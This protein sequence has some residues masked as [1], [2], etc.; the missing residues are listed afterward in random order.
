MVSCGK[1]HACR[2]GGVV[3][4]VADQGHGKEQ[5]QLGFA[6]A[7]GDGVPGDAV[8]GRAGGQRPE[9]LRPA[10]GSRGPQRRIGMDRGLSSRLRIHLGV[11][12]GVYF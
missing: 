2:G 9:M 1:W 5:Y 7:L 4:Q 3:A 8:A 10:R 12:E 11:D 6:Y